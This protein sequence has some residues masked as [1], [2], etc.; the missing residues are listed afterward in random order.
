VPVW[1]TANIVH[2]PAD[3]LS[4]GAYELSVCRYMKRI[5]PWR[6]P[7]ALQADFDVPEKLCHLR[8]AQRMVHTDCIQNALTSFPPLGTMGRIGRRHRSAPQKKCIQG[9]PPSAASTNPC[10][11]AQ[12]PRRPPYHGGGSAGESRTTGP[13][14]R[15]SRR[16][17]LRAG[18]GSTGPAVQTKS[19]WRQT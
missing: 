15:G 7:P 5:C 12:V 8:N 1:R 17:D 18:T 14:R 9:E 2:G 3:V 16:H 10:R 19:S 11:L 13:S 4:L 6:V